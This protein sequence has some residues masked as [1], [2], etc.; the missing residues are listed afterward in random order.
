LRGEDIPLL[1]RILQTVDI[2]D[3]LTTERPY[4]RAFTPEEA[5]SIMREETGKGWR[6]PVLMDVFAEL[7]PLFRHPA[8]ADTARLS[9]QALADTLE[10]YRKNSLRLPTLAPA[11]FTPLKSL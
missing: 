6:D 5:L 4:K 8:L 7:L 11:N 2:Y 3:A 1:A 9:L 10:Q